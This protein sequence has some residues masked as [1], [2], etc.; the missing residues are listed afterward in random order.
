MNIK[1]MYHLLLVQLLLLTA[2]VQAKSIPS[3]TTNTN[4]DN[5]VWRLDNFN[6][7]LFWEEPQEGKSSILVN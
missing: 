2:T 6:K 1:S 5:K 3:Y 4:K 7:E